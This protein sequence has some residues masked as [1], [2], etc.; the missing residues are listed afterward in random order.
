MTDYALF[1]VRVT[2]DELTDEACI[3]PILMQ[4]EV[5]KARELRVTVVGDQ[6]FSCA[7]YSQDHEETAV[8]WRRAISQVRH[9]ATRVSADLER[10]LLNM[11]HDCGLTFGAFDLI[12]TPSGDIV[13]VE[14]NPNGQWAWIEQMTQLPIR[15]A[16]LDVLAAR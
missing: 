3:A 15:E 16:I 12:E 5:S 6:V 14:L 7:L 10:K 11:T 2:R 1:T 13:F 4:E 9:E 8:D